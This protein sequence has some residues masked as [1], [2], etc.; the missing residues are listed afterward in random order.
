[1]L[2]KLIVSAVILLVAILVFSPKGDE[3]NDERA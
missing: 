3:K 1:M 2:T